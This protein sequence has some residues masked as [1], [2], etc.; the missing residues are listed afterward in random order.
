M[1]SKHVDFD[2]CAQKAMR[3]ALR[4][5]LAEPRA[6]AQLEL[7]LQ[8]ESE[9]RGE[10]ARRLDEG[11]GGAQQALTQAGAAFLERLVYSNERLLL[12]A[13]GLLCVDEV[14][15]ASALFFPLAFRVCIHCTQHTAR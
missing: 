1:S 5:E 6:R 15:V 3:A 13:D 9:R 12:G 2:V 7:V 4:A 10:C 14:E 11:L 8:A